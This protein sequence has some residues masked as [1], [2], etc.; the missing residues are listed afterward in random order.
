[1][2]Y[3][4]GIFGGTSLFFKTTSSSLS[5]AFRMMLTASGRLKSSTLLSFILS[6]IKL[7]L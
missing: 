7:K 1:M 6:K 4:E 2:P 5:G 3:L